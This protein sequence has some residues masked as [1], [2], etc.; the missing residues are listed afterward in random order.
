[1]NTAMKQTHR[2]ITYSLLKFGSG[3]ASSLTAEPEIE[4]SMVSVVVI[5]NTW[6]VQNQE[7][8]IDY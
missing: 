3:K 1:M 8:I 6:I 2:T 4:K 5:T 7:L